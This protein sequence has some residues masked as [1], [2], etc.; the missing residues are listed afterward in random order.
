[1]TKS[2]LTAITGGLFFVAA[3]GVLWKSRTESINQVIPP[4]EA[5]D[6]N[7]PPLR[8]TTSDPLRSTSST[9]RD[10][11]DL[12]EATKDANRTK[13]LSRRIRKLR[14]TLQNSADPGSLISGFLEDVKH[15][16]SYEFM[17][18][19]AA[20]ENELAQLNLEDDAKY[21]WLA[22]LLPRIKEPLQ[23]NRTDKGSS[24]DRLFSLLWV[25]SRAKGVDPFGELMKIENP[26]T[27]ADFQ[28]GLLPVM[29]TATGQSHSE[30]F[31]SLDNDTKAKVSQRIMELSAAEK[32][33]REQSLEMFLGGA[34]VPG[35]NEPLVENWFS[36]TDWFWEN[37]AAIAETVG[38][39]DPS[40]RKDAAIERICRMVHPSDPMAAKQWCDSMGD[41][42]RA[43]RIR[44]ELKL[45]R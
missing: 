14:E 21:Q 32:I 28:I 29:L 17:A 44:T 6:R 10:S 42:N 26:A 15:L 38:K 39:A 18:L 13:L 8:R 20:L 22:D 37:S 5:T 16:N 35:T 43:E 34:G 12:A 11:E 1:M 40:P 3:L 4:R 31:D 2:S 24:L 36:D 30:I 41:A 25:K 45:P 7:Q 23:N 33:Y 9:T 19:D 27:R